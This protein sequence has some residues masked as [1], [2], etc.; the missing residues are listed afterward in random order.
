[1]NPSPASCAARFLRL[2]AALS[3][4]L[5]RIRASAALALAATL[6]SMAARAQADCPPTPQMPTAE[7]VQTLL[8][9]A[10]DHG[11]LWRLERDGRVGWLYGTL[12]VGRQA[13]SAPGPRLLA[14]LREAD[15]VALEVDLTDPGIAQAMVRA[16]APLRAQEAAV[17]LPA[18]L[19]ARLAALARSECANALAQQPAL[20]Q[21]LSLMVLAGR[22]DGLDPAYAQEYMLAGFARAAGKTLRGLETLDL[23]LSALAPEKP[24]ELVALVERSVAQVENGQARSSMLALAGIAAGGVAALRYQLWRLD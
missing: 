11:M 13:W 20:M 7:Q 6:C 2:P 21:A 4:P 16:E 17:T 1:M 12:H 10:R 14:A 23:Q 15:V 5:A 8:R 24:E 3:R 18:P 22:R 19:R 9:E